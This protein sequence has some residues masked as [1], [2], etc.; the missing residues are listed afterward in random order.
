[1]FPPNLINFGLI[2]ERQSMFVAWGNIL[3][4]KYFTHAHFFAADVNIFRP[5]KLYFKFFYT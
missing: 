4:T 2:R 3:F 1:M 5:S